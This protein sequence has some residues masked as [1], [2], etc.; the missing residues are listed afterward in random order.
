[1]LTIQN[2]EIL[3]HKAITIKG[4]TFVI[5]N[6]LTSPNEYRIVIEDI[7]TVHAPFVILLSRNK[8]TFD[9][10]A[11]ESKLYQLRKFGSKSTFLYKTA[12]KNPIEFMEILQMYLNAL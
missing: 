9:N 4:Y 7:G 8:A 1:M 6:V 3:I 12:M 5:G 11:P 2:I 10:I